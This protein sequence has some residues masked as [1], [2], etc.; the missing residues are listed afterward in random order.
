MRAS[1]PAPRCVLA[2]LISCAACAAC[3][4]QSQGLEPSAPADDRLIDV[5]MDLLPDAAG[6]FGGVS[7]RYC[8]QGSPPRRLAPENRRALPFL[9]S[10]TDDAGHALPVDDQGVRT[11]ELRGCARLVIDVARLADTLA[12]KD[13][14]QRVGDDVVATPDLWLWRPEPFVDEERLRLRVERGGFDAALPWVADRQGQMEV[15]PATF[16]LKSDAAFG[17]FPTDEL[18]LMGVRL[19][20]ARLDDGRAP[21]ALSRWLADSV[22]A[23]ATV[24]GSFPA[25]RLNVLVVPTHVSR[26]IVVGFYS[27]GGGPT[28]LFYVGDG[29]ADLD[30]AD[31]DATGR[32]AL[33]HELAHALLPPVEG[34]D[35]W[36][37]E[38]IATWY[39]D[40]LARRAGLIADDRAYWGELLRGLRTGRGRAEEDRLSVAQASQHMHQTG[41]YQ[42]AYWA[43]VALALQAE[44]EARQQGASLDD[45]VRE[46]RRR[47]PDDDQT[48]P[49]LALLAAVPE[50]KAGVAAR[51]LERA[52]HAHKDQPWP[53]V[54]PTLARLG[55]SVDPL[56]TL[57]L[58]DQAPLAEVRRAI[59]RPA[60]GAVRPLA[61]R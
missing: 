3:A 20:V 36:L 44:V 58:D 16:R 27:R 25:R 4:T 33:T 18:E 43:G 52:F 29:A 12:D 51:A 30:D 5:D 32:W 53:D 49:A 31:L 26:P 11:R 42:H 22:R 48:R 7:L 56:G 13:L 57:T 8:P 28:A 6:G 24:Q 2:L 60:G 45:L 41:A 46:L 55:V 14:A 37:N 9:V 50:G 35:A 39:Q 19:T 38:G 54:E 10:A 61:A 47:F 23:V 17:R 1:S 40:L 15:T 21:P 34:S 59:T